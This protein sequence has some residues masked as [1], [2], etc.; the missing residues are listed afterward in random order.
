M[1]EKSWRLIWTRRLW[2]IKSLHLNRLV[3]RLPIF[4][5]LLLHR[6]WWTPTKISHLV[7]SCVDFPNFGFVFGISLINNE[8]VYNYWRLSCL[9]L[10]KNLQTLYI[11]SSSKNPRIRRIPI[12]RPPGWPV[13]S[14]M[15]HRS[16]PT[17]PLTRHR[18]FGPEAEPGTQWLPARAA[19]RPPTRPVRGVPALSPADVAAPLCLPHARQEGP[20]GQRSAAVYVCETCAQGEV[21]VLNIWLFYL[22][23]F[24]AYFITMFL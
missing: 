6:C 24:I 17:S 18:L 3:F 19:F 2:T 20:A 9:A 1:R 21:G 5:L 23:E 13:L 12:L 14:T 11:D 4:R 7:R 16:L 8:L 22:D 10:G 15:L